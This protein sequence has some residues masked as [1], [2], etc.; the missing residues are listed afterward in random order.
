MRLRLRTID[1]LAIFTFILISNGD[2]N[3][4]VKDNE[5]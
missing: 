3:E 5:K 1:L 2:F 4:E